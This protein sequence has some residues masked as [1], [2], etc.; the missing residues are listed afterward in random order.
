MPTLK[1][2]SDGSIHIHSYVRSAAPRKSLVDPAIRYQC[3]HPDCTHYAFRS[4][5]FGK[6]SLCSICMSVSFVLTSEQLRM[7]RPHC[8][9]CGKQADKKKET[10]NKRIDILE[11]ILSPPPSNPS[12]PPNPQEKSDAINIE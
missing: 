7:R 6:R 1:K 3:S 11:S 9:F 5:L 4:E 12:V 8:E 2:N 10:F